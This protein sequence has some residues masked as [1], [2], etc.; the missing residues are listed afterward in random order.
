MRVNEEC[1][2][3]QRKCGPVP[4]SLPQQCLAPCEIVIRAAMGPRWGSSA[5]PLFMSISCF[6]FCCLSSFSLSAFSFASFA[7]LIFSSISLFLWFSRTASWSVRK[8]ETM[9]LEGKWEDCGREGKREKIPAQF[10]NVEWETNSE[11]QR[12]QQWVH[13]QWGKCLTA[14]P[15]W[16]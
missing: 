10:Y 5:V 12:T 8:R 3:S 13:T 6:F 11:W 9:K 2:F 7:L 16:I 4:P 15:R 14:V 1:D